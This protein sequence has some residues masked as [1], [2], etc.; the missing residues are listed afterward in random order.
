MALLR[1]QAFANNASLLDVARQITERHIN[2]RDFT[3]EGD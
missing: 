3:I 1:G 2:F